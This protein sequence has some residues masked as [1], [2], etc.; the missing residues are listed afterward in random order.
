MCDLTHTPYACN[1]S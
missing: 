1:V